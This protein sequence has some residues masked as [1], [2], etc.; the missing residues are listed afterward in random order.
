MQQGMMPQQGMMGQGGMGM[1]GMGMYPQ[2]GGQMGMMGPMGGGGMGMGLQP[3]MGMGMGVGMGGMGQQGLAMGMIPMG[4]NGMSIGE[5]QA[6]PVSPLAR[7]SD[8][9]AQSSPCRGCTLMP[10][11][12][13]LESPGA[14]SRSTKWGTHHTL[15]GGM[16][17]TEGDK[18][19]AVI[20]ATVN[21]GTTRVYSHSC[22]DSVDT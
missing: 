14:T 2:A 5:S 15:E 6:V 10:T 3:G 19:T 13:N 11:V 20:M 22:H 21:R 7:L 17:G 1:Q 4:G 18:A 9:K 8:G 16:A 12:H